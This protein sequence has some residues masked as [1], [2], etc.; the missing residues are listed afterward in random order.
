MFFGGAGAN[1]SLYGG[2]GDD[3][4]FA[5]DGGDLIF[6]N[7]GEGQDVAAASVDYVLGAGVSVEL[8]TTGWIGGTATINLTGNDLGNEIWG[9]DGINPA[10]RRRR[11]RDRRPDRLRR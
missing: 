7:A 6:E 1:D 8:M 4:Y 9:N 10:E 11:Q 5:D 3:T 2:T